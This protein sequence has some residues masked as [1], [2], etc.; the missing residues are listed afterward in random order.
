MVYYYYSNETRESKWII[1][2]DSMSALRI[3]AGT[4]DRYC[5][6]VN[7]IQKL[8]LKITS[9][10]EIIQHWIKSH[11]G[12]RGNEIADKL[13]NAGHQNNRTML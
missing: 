10:Q 2:T 13:A 9:P 6:I 11:V 7:E 5:N 3:I 4:T 1:L 12:I 8:I